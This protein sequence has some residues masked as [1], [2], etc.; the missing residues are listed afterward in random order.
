LR[1]AVIPAESLTHSTTRHPNLMKLPSLR[2]LLLLP[3]GT[4]CAMAA[5]PVPS[6]Y[7][8]NSTHQAY[9]FDTGS[10]TPAANTL[11]NLYGSPVATVTLGP[12]ADGWQDPADELDNPG[13]NKDGSW[14]LGKNGNITL[15]ML[16]APSAP[17]P[18]TFYRVFFEVHTVAYEGITPLPAF[19]TLGLTPEDLQQTVTEEGPDPLVSGAFWRRVKWTGYFD[20]VTTNA[21]AFALKPPTDK[22]TQIDSFEVFTQYQVVPEPS[23]AILLVAPALGWCVRRRRA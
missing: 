3:F 2:A 4:G 8:L 14:D 5:T 19:D 7:G 23:A 13:L 11:D 18:G 12:L 9:F 10:F 22:T 1:L 17:A 21:L 6:W 20:N 15:N 16:A